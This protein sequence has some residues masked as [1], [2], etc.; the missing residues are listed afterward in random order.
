[1]D[2]PGRALRP[3]GGRPPD[4]EDTLIRRPT[5]C[6]TSVCQDLAMTSSQRWLHRYQRG[7]RDQVWHELRQLGSTVRDFE[8][9][10]EA[11]L[12]CDEMAHRARQNIELIVERLSAD[13]YRFHGND[14][15]Q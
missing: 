7:Q 14:D 15:E 4:R 8:A 13:G 1:M 2:A 5:R 11:Q 3:E 10:E 12:V 6:D 9:A